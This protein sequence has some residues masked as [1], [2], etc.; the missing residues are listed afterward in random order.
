MSF[1]LYN[2][3][4]LQAIARPFLDGQPPDKSADAPLGDYARMKRFR[5]LDAADTDTNAPI[6]NFIYD[7]DFFRFC[8][9]DRWREVY[10]HSAD[11]EV[12][13]GSLDDLIAAFNQGS[14]VKVGIGGLCDDLAEQGNAI[15]H[16]VFV[17]LGSCYCY[18]EQ[19][20]FIGASQ[21]V[22]RVAPTIP[23]LYRSHKWDF[24]WLVPRT[25]GYVAR[26]LCDPYSLKFHKSHSR[27]PIRWFVGV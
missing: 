8:V 11:G 12:L 15:G 16:E 26:W 4:G 13:S 19:K 24:G 21:P 27:H 9:N 18:T 10:S 20:L 5:E 6:R 1:F 23:L 25:D 2:Q 17:H 7:F 22:V 3:D 14:E